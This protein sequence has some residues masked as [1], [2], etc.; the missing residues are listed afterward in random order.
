MKNQLIAIGSAV[1]AMMALP[2]SADAKS[3]RLLCYGYGGTETLADFQAL[4]KLAPENDY[5]FDYSECAANDGSDLWFTDASGVVIPHEVDTWVHGGESFLWVKI[6]EVAASG[7]VAYPTAITMHWGDAGAKQTT[8]DKVWPQFA[9]VWHMNGT[10]EGGI[11]QNEPDATGNGLDAV[12]TAGYGGNTSCMTNAV[13]VIGTGRR[14]QPS[15]AIHNGLK[16]SGYAAKLAN[17]QVLTASGWFSAAEIP[18]NSYPR[19]FSASATGADDGWSASGFGNDGSSIS[20]WNKLQSATSGGASK[21]WGDPV[22]IGNFRSPNWVL[23]TLVVNGTSGAI[24]ANGKRVAEYPSITAVKANTQGLMIGNRYNASKA[25]DSN[26]GLIGYYDEVRLY[27]GAA[28]ADRIAADYATMSN[29][30]DFLTGDSAVTAAVWTGGAGDGDV[31]NSDNWQCYDSRGNLKAGEVPTVAT[32]VQVS[33]AGVK[34]NVPAGSVLAAKSITVSSCTLGA[35]CDW[36]GLGAF[37]CAPD[38][39]V[40]LNGFNLQIAGLG[41]ASMFT[42]G[43]D[44][45]TVELAVSFAAATENTS[46]AIGGNLR[47]V[48]NGAGTFTS[49]MAQTYSGGTI[50]A[51]GTAQPVASG[52][53][54]AYDASFSVF[55]T[56]E[57]IVNAGATYVSQSKAAYRNDIVLSGGTLQSSLRYV[58]NMI[59]RVTANSTLY[60]D[61]SM[62]FGVPGRICDLGGKVLTVTLLNGNCYLRIACDFSENGGKLDFTNSNGYMQ[63]QDGDTVDASSVDFKMG[64]RMNH[65]PGTLLKVHDYEAIHSLTTAAGETAGL[66]V[67][68]TFIP[69]SSVFRGGEMQNGSSIDLSAK[70]GPWSITSSQTKYNTVTFADG[71]TV[72]LILGT[73]EIT[74]DVPVV[75]WDADTRPANVATLTFTGVANGKNALFRAGADGVYLVKRGLVISFH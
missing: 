10:V 20:R 44:A 24:Y 65:Q 50:V 22:D 31:T 35:D 60:M 53:N 58:T 34:M 33:G 32:D 68:G 13:G 67:Y 25:A 47:F 42:N 27:D 73:R 56:G 62:V 5:G 7:A 52:E 63:V 70:T 40:D 49:S 28:S 21:S 4:V 15:N 46:T 37:A 1:C 66:A 11:A 23:L 55:G 14:N 41:G 36:R 51:A 17:E 72:N 69:T 2:A 61:K 74:P 3:T 19:F 48:K 30:T 45:T 38:T 64:C 18:N 43:V 29:P 6:P 54:A 9:G 59:A 26:R 57:V 75:T 12:P 16:V 39:V 71:A 8:T